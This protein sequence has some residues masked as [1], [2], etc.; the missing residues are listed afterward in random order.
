[1]ELDRVFYFVLWCVVATTRLCLLCVRVVCCVMFVII[2]TTRPCVMNRNSP[3]VSNI[4]PRVSVTNLLPPIVSVLA[5][6]SRPVASLPPGN[7]NID[8][9]NNCNQGS[10]KKC[11]PCKYLE[12]S[13]YFRYYFWDLLKTA[14]KPILC[15]EDSRRILPDTTAPCLE[16]HLTALVTTDVSMR[17]LPMLM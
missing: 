10:T 16:D 1:M 7:S 5:A 13:I 15:S 12:V 9:C 4:W 2:T 11:K 6:P 14:S 3:L 17:S 8:G